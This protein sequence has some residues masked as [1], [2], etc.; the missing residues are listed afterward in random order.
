MRHLR[1]PRLHF[2][3]VTIADIKIDA[4]SRDE[5]PTIFRDLQ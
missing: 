5:I 1:N 2:G 3:E 4:R